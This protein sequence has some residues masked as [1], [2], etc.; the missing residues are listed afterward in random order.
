[1]TTRGI[2]NNNP[3]NVEMVRGEDRAPLHA[4]IYGRTGIE[5]VS[6]D[7][8]QRFA[9]YSS[10]LGGIAAMVETMNMHQENGKNTIRSLIGQWAPPN[11][12][13]TKAYIAQVS[14]ELGIGPDDPLPSVA[15]NPSVAKALA[16]AIIGVEV[17]AEQ[18]LVSPDMIDAG[19]DLAFNPSALEDRNAAALAGYQ[20]PAVRDDLYAAGP[21]DHPV[22]P[23]LIPNIADAPV[24][25]GAPVSPVERGADLPSPVF[26]GS[27]FPGSLFG[28]T[29]QFATPQP[30]AAPDFGLGSVGNPASPFGFGNVAGL[31]AAQ[32]PDR[33]G[34]YPDGRYNPN[35]ATAQSLGVDQIGAPEPS[36]SFNED[37]SSREPSSWSGYTPTFANGSEPAFGSLGGGLPQR[38]EVSENRSSREPESWAGSPSGFGFGLSVPAQPD[39]TLG[40][41]G[42]FQTTAP[43]DYAA[44][45]TTTA[46]TGATLAGQ[47]IGTAREPT[48][49][50]GFG[51]NAPMDFSKAKMNP[52]AVTAA[53]AAADEEAAKNKALAE[54]Y[55]PPSPRD[56]MYSVAPAPETPAIAAAKRALPPA[57][58]QK[59]RLPALPAPVTVRSVPQ[60]RPALSP[61]E[62]LSAA[63]GTPSQFM[64]SGVTPSDFAKGIAAAA[65]INKSDD[66]KTYAG[67]LGETKSGLSGVAFDAL[68]N[69]MAKATGQP[70]T[71]GL[72][73]SLFGDVSQAFGFGTPSTPGIGVSN[74]PSRTGMYVQGLGGTPVW[75]NYT[76]EQQRATENSAGLWSGVQ[77]LFGFGAG[78]NNGW[79][80]SGSMGYG[81]G[82]SGLW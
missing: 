8:T 28:M 25:A 72:F 54:A 9:Q 56:D 78:A 11:E 55:T 3:G 74:S 41:T 7:G 26:G 36:R 17:G 27:A 64:G 37:R 80:P 57:P 48:A 43:T 69:E 35:F 34:A 20:A 39:F 45:R 10:M 6:S 49:P 52:L 19:V 58:I 30:T 59:P 61:S 65:L 40:S 15:E 62:A 33:Q 79:G 22:P 82:T 75:A 13:N 32:E 5:P 2:R 68:S 77:N 67:L 71:K 4:G 14:R 1:M 24:F 51:I 21:L 23:G 44:P 38:M 63:I 73:G 31:Y 18:K 81:A 76:P 29:P 66:A 50:F 16:R 70:Q 47:A 12:N 42:A 60:P 53:V 46:D